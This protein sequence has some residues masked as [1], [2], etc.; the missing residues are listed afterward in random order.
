M[1]NED[2]QEI[3]QRIGEL[4]LAHR[5][6]DDEI[7]HLAGIAYIDELQFKRMKRRKLL[8]K[9]TIGRLRSSLIPDLDA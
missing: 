8:L 2:N 1:S 6:L 3:R 7:T 4:I 5:D 9:D